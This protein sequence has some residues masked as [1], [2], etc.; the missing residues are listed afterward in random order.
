MGPDSYHPYNDGRN[1][2]QI[3]ADNKGSR[4]LHS[5]I[6]YEKPTWAERGRPIIIPWP[7]FLLPFLI[8]WL[9]TR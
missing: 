8:W 2:D 7:V 5:K 3:E 4:Y 6:R 1:W 9:A